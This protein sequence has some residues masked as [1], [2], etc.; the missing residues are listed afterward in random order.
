MRIKTWVSGKFDVKVSEKGGKG[1]YA[2]QMIRKGE[3]IGVFGGIVIHEKEVEELSRVVP[4][5]RLNLD[6]AMYIY[7]DILMLHDYENGCD[8]M[9]FVNHS[10]DPNSHIVNSIIL[11]ASRD[12]AEGE[13]ICWDYRI[14][15]DIGNWEYEFVCGCGTKKCTGKV[16][17]GPKHRQRKKGS[18]SN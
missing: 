3:V 12:I 9:C 2:N 11:L 18:Q 4:A 15:D 14:T 6:H 10:C 1:T 5:D 8:P 17:V 13:E 16:Q 7:K